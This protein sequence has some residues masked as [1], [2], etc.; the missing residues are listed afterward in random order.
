M[1]STGCRKNE[2][3][4]V[5]SACT[6]HISNNRNNFDTFSACDRTVN[7]GNYETI[8]SCSIRDVSIVTVVDGKKFNV[9]L[10]DVLYL[11]NIMYNLIGV[12]RVR[13][14]DCGVVID[15]SGGNP[16]RGISTIENEDAHQVKMVAHETDEGLY[17]AV[18]TINYSE[19]AYVTRHAEKNLWNKRLGY[20]SDETIKASLKHVCKVNKMDLTGN[21][22][23]H[24]DAC[25]LGKWERSF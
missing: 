22:K 19:R 11:P 8:R 12:L 14:N 5:D 24:C 3:C 13:K 20:C 9:T 15:S 18:L 23:I 21:G 1:A 4:V 6:R 10:Q 2:Y 16:Q 25:V 17:R 7:V